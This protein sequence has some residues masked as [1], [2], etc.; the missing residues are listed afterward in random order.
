MGFILLC[1][2]MSV[3]L[4]TLLIGCN[5]ENRQKDDK[6]IAKKE[7]TSYVSTSNAKNEI[8]NKLKRLKDTAVPANLSSGAMCYSMAAPPDRVEY[9]CPICHNKTLYEASKDNYGLPRFISWEL[10]SCRRAVKEIKGMSV[11]LDETSFCKKCKP[12]AKKHELTLVVKYGK[13]ETHRVKNVRLD[14]LKLLVEFTNGKLKHDVGAGGEEPL[15]NYLTRL[16]KLLG[17][18]AEDNK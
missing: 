1:C 2:M 3:V 16:H 11:E 8:L 15:K 7:T 14:D 4:L 10:T 6:P 9:V 13:N 12:D 17:V 18:P 5:S